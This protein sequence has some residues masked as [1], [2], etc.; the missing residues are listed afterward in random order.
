MNLRR[1]RVIFA[2]ATVLVALMASF[3]G[4]WSYKSHTSTPQYKARKLMAEL[5]RQKPGAL[6][7]WLHDHHYVKPPVP[8]S[9]E[10]LAEALA[11]LGRPAVPV[12]ITGLVDKDWCV[13]HYSAVAIGNIGGE[14]RQAEPYLIS[15]LEDSAFEVR[16]SAAEAL[17]KVGR[18][19]IGVPFLVRQ[20][21]SEHVSE[22]YFAAQGLGNIGP[23]AKDAV[24]AL[25]RALEADASVRC[26]AA[27]ALGQIRLAVGNVVQ[28]LGQAL[29]D[30][31]R[32]VRWAA[33]GAL[34]NIGAQ[35]KEAIP[36]LRQALDDRDEG[37]RQ[38]A[39]EALVKL[40][41]PGRAV[42]VLIASLE[43]KHWCNRR[44]AAKILGDVG[45]PAKAAIPA[46]RKALKDEH[47]EVREAATEALK[48]IQAAPATRKAKR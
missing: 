7:Q 25:A 34:G 43:D 48:K 16:L 29:Q 13:R 11:D 27:I 31:D 21:R 45:P 36:L 41:V 3:A 35:A 40:G 5:R 8:L 12:L 1:K 2:T 24:P 15:A 9:E 39:A 22:R 20:L 26:P 23:D 17:A 42:P 32:N 14:A 10:D 44:W 28:L 46:L 47:A 6:T 19:D 33:A 30:E 38:T 18:I 4:Y 37:V